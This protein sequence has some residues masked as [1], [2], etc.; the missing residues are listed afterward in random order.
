MGLTANIATMFTSK[1][2]PIPAIIA[3][4]VIIRIIGT[5]VVIVKFFTTIF[6]GVE[7]KIITGPTIYPPP[8][9]EVTIG[10]EVLTATI[11]A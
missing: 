10:M 6:T 2:C 11:I 4:I 1:I 3:I 7:G 9:F 5:K 8:L